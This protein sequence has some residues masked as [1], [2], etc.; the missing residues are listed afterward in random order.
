MPVSTV[1]VYEKLKSHLGEDGT[2]ILL[3][4]VEE[5]IRGSVATKEDLKET[6]VVLRQEISERFVK[7]EGEVTS[8]KGEVV[9]M[10]EDIAVL[11]ATTATKEDVHQMRM[12]MKEDIHQM[13]LL[14]IIIIILVVLLSPQVQQVIGRVLGITR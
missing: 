2:K 13:R 14:M 1:E 5:T 4:Y 8:L 12:A 7:I 11:K 6:Q 10:K 3:S 9:S